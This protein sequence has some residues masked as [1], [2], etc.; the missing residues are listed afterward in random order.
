[1]NLKKTNVST[2]IFL[3]AASCP[4]KDVHTPPPQNVQQAF[5]LHTQNSMSFVLRTQKALKKKQ[6]QKK[7][8]KKLEKGDKKGG[9]KST[10]KGSKKV[11]S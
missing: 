1:M 4:K 5:V 3:T 8:E 6:A 10:K 2:S 7:S 9:T 11:Y